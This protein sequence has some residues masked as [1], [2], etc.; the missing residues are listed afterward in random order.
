MGEMS[1]LEF[2]YDDVSAIVINRVGSGDVSL[3]PGGADKVSGMISCDDEDF[4]GRTRINQHHDQL[5]IDFP[6][7]GPFS[8]PSLD[9]EL[10]V[11][12]GVNFQVNTGSADIN[13]SVGLGAAKINTGS[14]AV[15]LDAVGALDANTGSGDITVQAISD[16]GSRLNSGSGDITI[17]QIAAPVQ[18]R[19]ASGDL[20]VHD[21]NSPL[22]ANTASG[23][24]TVPSTT[25]SLELRTASGSI[26]VG[27]AGDL[28][29]WLDL[30]S[31]SG[32]V[33]I[34]L[35]ATEQ[36]GEGEPFVAIKAST[37]S[38]DISVYRA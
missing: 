26:S 8:S 10:A 36:P 27:V 30:S 14:G 34:D 5:R 24:I 1:E 20:T 7:P 2:V 4:L 38:G 33:G 3:V 31:V 12:E 9:I 11:P 18:A 28:P 23:D 15:N 25:A 21:A 29:A 32:Q 22:Q 13:V 6:E 35:D 37:A 19:T 16:E 17:T